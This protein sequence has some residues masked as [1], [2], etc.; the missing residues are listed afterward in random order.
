MRMMKHCW[1]AMAVVLLAAGCAS[2]GSKDDKLR[3]AQYAWSAAI[4][5]GDFEG[6]WNLVE[7]EYRKAH[8]MTPVEFERYK[9]VGISRY[10]DLGEQALAGGD[11]AREIDLG[12]INKHTMTE[13]GMRYTE[14]WHYDEEAKTWWQMSGLPDLWQGE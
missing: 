3:E 1:L 9:H 12:V 10:H 13:R 8:P 5:W 11:V 6:A 2:M 4:R 14:R 7:P